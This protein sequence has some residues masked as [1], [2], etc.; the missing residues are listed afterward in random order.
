L[1]AASGEAVLPSTVDVFINGRQVANQAVPPGPFTVDNLP[2]ISGAGEMQ[3]VV[4]DTLGRQQVISQPYYSGANLLRAGLDQYS[5]ELGSVR[6]DYGLSSVA[7]GDMLASGTFRRGLTDSLTVGAHGEAQASGA[8]AAGLEGAWRVGTLGV[9]NS[10]A[11]IGGDRRGTGW[12]GGFGFEH[13]GRRLSLIAGTQ[14]RSSAFSQV[15]DSVLATRPKLRSFVGA[16]FNLRRAGSIQLAYGKQSFWDAPEAQ[17]IGLSFSLSVGRAGYLGLYAGHSL[18]GGDQT[19]IL[20]NWT[21]S[22]GERRSAS[23]SGVVTRD[24]AAGS[25]STA[26]VAMQQSLPAGSGSSWYLSAST[27]EL[28]RASYAYQGH[29]G[30]IGVEYARS[31]QVDGLRASAT[32]GVALTAAGV[33]PARRL[34]SSF[35]VVQVADYEGLTVYVDNQPVG[36]TDNKGRVLIDGLRAYESNAV[37]V[38][39]TEVPMDASLSVAKM[40]LTPAYRSGPLVAFPVERSHAVVLRLVRDDGSFV[41]AGAAV[42]VEQRSYPVG[43]DGLAYIEE[44]GNASQ[45]VAHWSGGQCR[46]VLQRPAGDEPIPDLGR[47]SCMASTSATPPK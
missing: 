12:L 7:Y 19:D 43:M 1:L 10:T 24:R 22:F 40:T 44:I 41:P 29:A 5:F 15:G 2:A 39:P 9:L 35:A 42:A 47:V 3:V 17:T 23:A 27:D 37:S 13:S 6:R 36:K 45:A 30:L 33:M 38:D 32:G 21:M 11:A 20:L 26:T 14:F 31:G 46:F 16:S 4:T 18:A 25:H 28:Q 34:D 8:A